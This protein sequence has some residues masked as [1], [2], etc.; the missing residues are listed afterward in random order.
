MRLR[1]AF[2]AH[3]PVARWGPL[4]H[5]LCLEQPGVELEWLA[6]GF[7]TP[8]R[9][10][11]ERAD[12]G[13]FVEPP[14]EAGLTGL[15]LDTSQMVVA[16]AVGHQLARHEGDLSVAQILDEP[17]PDGRNVHPEWRAFW[18]LDEQRGGPPKFIGDGVEN[19]AEALEILVSGRVI[20]TVPEWVPS[21]LT[22]PG[23]VALPLRDAPRV[24]TRLVW[25]SEN[26][27]PAVDWLVDLARDWTR[28]GEG[29]ATAG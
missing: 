2:D 23:V 6:V 12:V 16:M 29:D 20:A 7:P 10:L 28:R 22:H 5:V 11:L 17:F 27:N 3:L 1:V 24:S 14:Q 19:A 4:F 26:G 9:S 13:V 25:R 8:E 21:G 15:T 18:T